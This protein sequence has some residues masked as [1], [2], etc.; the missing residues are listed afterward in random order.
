MHT[1]KA[2]IIRHTLKKMESYVVKST[3]KIDR[4]SVVY[5]KHNKFGRTEFDENTRTTMCNGDRYDAGYDDTYLFSAMMTIPS[6]MDGEKVYLKVDIGGESLAKVNGEYLSAF[7]CEHA[8]DWTYRNL[9][10]VRNPAKAGEVLNIEIEDTVC[11]GLFCDEA[12]AGAKS[13]RYTIGESSLVAVDTR[14]EDYWFF[15]NTAFQCLDYIDDPVIRERVYNAVDDSIHALEYDFGQERFS[16]SVPEADRILREGLAKIRYIPQGEVVMTG[17]SHLDIAWLWT[18]RELARK[19]ARTFANTLNLMEN[20]PDFKYTQSQAVVYTY[21]KKYYPELYEKVKQAVKD[22][23]WEIVGNSWV[24]ADTNLASGESLI[25]Q[26]LYGRKFFMEEFGVS[27]DTYWLP[28]CFGFTWALPQIIK[29]SGMKYFATSKLNFNDTNVFPYTVCRW[30]GQTGDEIIAYINKQGYSGEYDPDYIHTVWSRNGEAATTGKSLGM[31]GYGDGGGGATYAQLERAKYMPMVPGMIKTRIGTTRDFFCGLE[32]KWDDLPVWD[33]DMYYEN[34]RGTFTSQHFVKKNNRY[35][36]RALRRTEIL[37]NLFSMDF[38]P[39]EELEEYW[40]I[41]LTNQFHDILPGTSIHEVFDDVRNDYAKLNSRLAKFDRDVADYFAAFP[42]GDGE[43]AVVFN[44]LPFDRTAETCVKVRSRNAVAYTPDGKACRGYTTIDGDGYLLRFIAEDVPSIG[45][46]IF[47]IGEGVTFDCPVMVNTGLLENDFVRV[48]FDEN[49]NIASFYDKENDREVLTGIGN[50]LTVYTDKCVHETAWN[51]ELDYLKHRWDLTT[52]E[53]I[54]VYEN[55]PTSASLRIV[56]KFNKSTI[57]Q[58]IRLGVNSRRLD[59]ETTVDWFE[60]EKIL[61]ASFPVSVRNKQATYEMAHGINQHPTHFNTSYD[62]AKFEVCG[63]TFADLSE[64]DYGVSIL[65]DCKY[66]YNIHDNLMNITLMRAPTCPDV[67]ADKGTWNFTYSL[68][69][70][71]GDWTASTTQEA[72]SLNEPLKAYSI[73]TDDKEAIAPTEYSAVRFSRQD[74]VLDAFK[75]A[76]DGQGYIMRFYESKQARG[77]V[78][79]D[80][81]FTFAKAIECNMMEVDE[82]EIARDDSSFELFIKPFEVKTI[83]IVM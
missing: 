18:S 46:K 55:T 57:I 5:G 74:I 68:Y 59:F 11:C 50:L 30:K 33:G 78:K 10:V 45:F 34:H 71:A 36:E 29:R 58:I 42:K 24:E 61:K 73:P 9:A 31:F 23:K 75:Q 3:K 2:D 56:R 26:L 32:N 28:D 4:W 17:H 63:H 38:F 64:G 44:F 67:T 1:L 27:S 82:Q 19:T 70:H 12:M 79:V 7:T 21:I 49:G 72:H 60:T 66:G 20:Y 14:V 48:L 81:P 53:S 6:E 65:N 8:G 13:H 69:P 37:K 43:S 15:V 16:E 62:L 83:R 54:E 52:A 39:Q 41:L 35:G 47:T 40:K 51:L 80:F 77:K 76:E 25:R 22:G